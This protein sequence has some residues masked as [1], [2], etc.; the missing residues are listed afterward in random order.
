MPHA[1][2]ERA[3]NWN[4]LVR[5]APPAAAPLSLEAAKA[6]L[7]V[8][9]L[10]FDAKIQGF[11]DDAVAQIDGPDGAGLALIT[12]TWRLSLDVWAPEIVI[13][14]RPVQAILGVTYRDLA[15]A[16]QTLD[17]ALYD[18]D[19]DHAPAAIVPAWGAC[20]PAH[21]PG[22]GVIKVTFRAG[23]GDAAADVPGDLVGALKLI[24]ADRFANREATSDG[25]LS[26]LPNGVAAVLARYSAGP[27]A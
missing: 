11:V 21:R 15:D 27:I 6:H 18:C 16:E 19:L 10:A 25:A 9:T 5:T 22:R 1:R 17:P 2:A 20:F 24:V 26:E 3:S 14:L 8:D 7:E 13:P 23:F 4:R 12:Q